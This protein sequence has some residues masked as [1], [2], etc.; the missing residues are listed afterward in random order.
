MY[1]YIKYKSQLQPFDCK[2]DMTL[3]EHTFPRLHTSSI[4]NFLALRHARSAL[5][6]FVSRNSL[7]DGPDSNTAGEGRVGAKNGTSH[8]AATL[9]WYLNKRR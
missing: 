1:V 2:N 8:R 7:K 5:M 4:A 6:S 3:Y 9:T